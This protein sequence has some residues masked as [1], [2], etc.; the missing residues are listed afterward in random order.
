M[1]L[2]FHQEKPLKKLLTLLLTLLAGFIGSKAIAVS[3]EASPSIAFFYG[4]KPPWAELQAFDWVAVD[5][6]HVPDPKLP[7]LAHT[8]L[9]AYVALGEVQPSRPYAAQIPKNWFVGENKDWG[10]RLIDQSQPEWPKFFTDTIIAPLWNSGYRTFFMDTL[11]SYH[12]FAKTPQKRAAQEAGMVSV[13]NAVK[14]RYPQARFIFNRGFEI[15]GRTHQHLDAVVAESLFQGFDAGKAKYKVVSAEDREWLLG[16]LRRAKDEFR[17]PV[18]VIDYVPSSERELARK[19][20]KRILDLGFTPW[21]ATPDL[22]TLGVGALEVMPR[23]VLVVHSTMKDEYALRLSE[24]V[25]FA[26]MPLNYL[27]Y[28]PE[29]V[30][31][32][33]LP[34]YLLAGRYAGIVVWLTDEVSEAGRTHLLVW[35]AAQALEKLPIALLNPP[36]YLLEG[37]F[38]KSLGLNVGNA[39]TTSAPLEIVQQ[40]ALMGF[41]RAPSLAPDGFFPLT[42]AKGS[43]LL[44]LKQGNQHQVVAAITPWGGYILDQFSVITLPGGN[45]DRWVTNPFA[46]FSQA[47]QLPNIPVADVTTETGRRMLMVHMDGDGFVSRSELPGNPMAGEVVRD[48]VVNKYPLPMTISVIEAEISPTG[49]Y[50]G[51]SS[52]A[53]KIARDIFR[54]PNVAMAS[55]SYSHPFVWRKASA[56]DVNEGYNLRL[57]GYKFDLQR[58][59]EGSIEYINTRLAPAGKKVEIFF[60]TGDCIPGTDALA[61]TKKVG[62]M[63]MNGGDTVA[64]RSQPTLTQVEGLGV[65]REGGFQVFAPNQNEN[66]YTNNWLGPFYGFERVIETFELTETPRRL[67]PIDIYF[68]TYLTTKRAGMQSLDKIFGYAL[69]QETTPLFVSEYAR[70]V[71]DFEQLAIA[72]TATGWRVRGAT[73]LRTLRLPTVLGW[74]DLN[75]SQGVAG[76]ADQPNDRYVHLGRDAAELVLT[77]VQPN[78]LQLVSANAKV[79]DVERLPNGFRWNLSGHVPLQFTLAHTQSCRVKAGGRELTPVRQTAGFSHFEIKDHVARPLEAICRG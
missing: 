74:P 28:V 26:A 7:K 34:A 65:P 42:L 19:T 21:V 1:C 56:G 51:L 59:I 66:V 24:P 23:K 41:E 71:L 57:P 30:D 54:A 63:N 29:Y 52:A 48:R 14:Q 10:S 44:T 47:L 20:A 11:D 61:W 75:Q 79:E 64:T 43:P 55:H 39:L 37:A 12:L 36:V 15:L 76:F 32:Q 62:V 70:K 58:E 3:G 50:P 4:A 9:V 27:G 33:H 25:R 45:G 18:V 40:D 8:K 53:E 73:D 2:H 22:G 31:P 16:Q 17:L 72:K 49:L 5:P 35:L 38:G 69:K 68:H 67:K 13:I 77:E 78:G 60:W 46:F 6:G